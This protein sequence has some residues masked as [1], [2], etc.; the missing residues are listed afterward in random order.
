MNP[1]VTVL[2]PV[3]NAE[4][5]LKTAIESILKQ[6]FSD[7]ELL[8]INDGSTDGS[9]E[10]IRSFNDKRI[11]LFNNEQNLGIIKTLNKG[12]NLAK[13]EYIIRMDAD[14]ISLPDRLELQVKYM[15]EN[16][17]IGISGT[18]ARIFGDTK[19]FT[20]KNFT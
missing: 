4:K 7:F 11:R 16:P 20:I 9:E 10:I 12:L 15:E 1:K 5:Y 19:K 3:Y 18:Q 8:I 13:G 6:T 2:M 17:G 14:D